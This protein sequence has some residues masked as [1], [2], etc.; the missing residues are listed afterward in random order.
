M[1]LEDFHGATEQL[2][3]SS[4]CV[5]EVIPVLYTICHN[6][7]NLSTIDKTICDL[8]AGLLE[9]VDRRLGD[10][11]ELELYSVATLCD[12]RLVLIYKIKTPYN[13]FDINSVWQVL[14][15]FYLLEIA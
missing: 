10:V 3:S 11:E 14:I 15:M 13:N 2:S 8:K 9:S 12:V 7:T 4:A 5:S 6:L 1:V